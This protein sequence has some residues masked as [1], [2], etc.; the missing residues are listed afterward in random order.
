M[1]SEKIASGMSKK[2]V[3]DDRGKSVM[4][5]SV[6][7]SRGGGCRIYIYIYGEV[8]GTAEEKMTDEG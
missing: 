5:R 3:N 8:G 2:R 4:E 1:W 7:M 6:R